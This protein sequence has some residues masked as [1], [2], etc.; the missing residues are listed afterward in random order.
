MARLYVEFDLYLHPHW[1]VLY[2][3]LPSSAL[4]DDEVESVSI[5]SGQPSE[6]H[7]DVVGEPH[8]GHASLTGPGHGTSQ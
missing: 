3:G 8:H 2:I 5:I 6:S 1:P 7:P 4:A